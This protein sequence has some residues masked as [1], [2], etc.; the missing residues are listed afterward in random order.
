MGTGAI[1]EQI[2]LLLFDAIFHITAG[3]VK[4]LVQCGWFEASRLG[5]ITLTILGQISH[6]IARIIAFG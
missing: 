5:R 1:G 6:D 2:H 4:L 3:A